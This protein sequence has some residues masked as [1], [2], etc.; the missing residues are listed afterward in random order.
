M[1]P[2]SSLVFPLSAPRVKLLR[3]IVAVWVFALFAGMASGVSSFDDV[4]VAHT[5]LPAP[6]AK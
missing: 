2:R 3:A 4:R 1:N 5:V 6:D